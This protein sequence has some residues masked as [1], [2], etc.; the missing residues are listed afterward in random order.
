MFAPFAYGQ[1]DAPVFSCSFAAYRSFGAARNETRSTS[2][3]PRL[4]NALISEL[5]EMVKI[6]PV[7]PGFKY[8][9]DDSPNAFADSRSTVPETKGTV[10]IGLNLLKSEMNAHAMGGIAVAGICAHECAHIYQFFSPIVADLEDQE[11][12][13]GLFFELHADLLAGY[14]LRRRGWSFDN[15]EAFADSLF[16]KGD[17]AFNEPRHHG[18]PAQR[19]SAMREGYAYAKSHN[20]LKDCAEGGLTFVKGLSGRRPAELENT[21]IQSAQQ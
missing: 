16:N 2:G 15:I 21:Q 11:T 7:N 5:R 3:D 6:F 12:K 17:Y 18:T 8:I 20:T 10:Y 19:V 9:V 13:S 4:D 14:Y 1:E